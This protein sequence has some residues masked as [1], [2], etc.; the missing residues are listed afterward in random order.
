LTPMAKQRAEQRA[1]L[2]ARIAVGPEDRGTGERCIMGFNAGPPM[3][4]SAYNNNMQLV[5]SRDAVVILNEMVH[6]A[7]VIPLDGRPHLQIPQWS[8][9]SRGHFE[10]NTLVVDTVNFYEET[11]FPNSNPKLHVVERFTRV[12]PDVLM[13]EFT[14]DD[15]STWT[16]SWTAQVPMVKNSETLYE[17]A[18]HEG[19]YGMFNLLSAARVLVASILIARFGNLLLVIL[20]I[21]L[22]QKLFP[23]EF[24]RPFERC[25]AAEV[26]DALQ[27]RLSVG[28]TR[29]RVALAGRLWPRPGGRTLTGGG[30]R[31]NHDREDA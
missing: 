8:G 21:L 17:Y 24:G 18:C 5:Q 25:S 1:E 12:S 26:P 27:I 29:S 15:P 2:R 31:H 20:H 4:P 14:V 9:D 3:L 11:S 10:G 19:N 6:N 23:G 30:V 28:R 7:R 16:K 13:Y 22:G